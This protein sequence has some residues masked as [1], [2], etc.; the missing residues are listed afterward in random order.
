MMEY[1]EG[2]E[3]ETSGRMS[4]AIIIEKVIKATQYMHSI[5]R[6][7]EQRPGAL[8]G[9]G[10]QGFPWGHLG[11]SHEFNSVS[12]LESCLNSRLSAEGKF[13]PLHFTDF[14]CV[15]VHGDLHPRNILLTKQDEIV[16]LDWH[17]ACFY[18]VVFEIAGL[19]YNMSTHTMFFRK[20]LDALTEK[21]EVSPDDILRLNHVQSVSM[22]RFFY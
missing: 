13:E 21:D 20:L 12:H 1:I 5:T 15:L 2:E 17:T 19:H 4:E 16:L 9:G 18:P 14:S 22:S 7:L 11:V 3:L 6:G 10:A 8:S